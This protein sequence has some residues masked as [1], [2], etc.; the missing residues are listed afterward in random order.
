MP[1]QTTTETRT[2]CPTCGAAI[3]RQ[4]MSSCLYCGTP[5]E[6]AGGGEAAA[7]ETTATMARL[8]KMAEHKDYA[9]A[10]AAAPREADEFYAARRT[11]RRCF[12]AG[13]VAVVAAVA[14][15][16]SDVA[17]AAVA[18][19]A[20]VAVCAVLAARA[21]LRMRE[22][23]SL[24][25]MKRPAL[26]T[27]RRSETAIVSG[28]GRTVYYFDLEFEDGRRGEFRYPGRGVDN[29]PLVKG[30]TGIAYSRGERLLDFRLIRV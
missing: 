22:Q 11:L 19:V 1:T 9:A 5:I 12:A 15:A 26:V 25:V 21:A 2:H 6:L 4:D 23:R 18:P 10:M 14:A 7:R 28:R 17:L 30:N 8:A 16:S 20:V 3:A 29:P 13:A 24:P 27:D